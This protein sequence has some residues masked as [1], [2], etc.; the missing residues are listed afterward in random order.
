[1]TGS[2]SDEGQPGDAPAA[3]RDLEPGRAVRVPPRVEPRRFRRPVR[4]A[5][6]AGSMLL[7]VAA[8]PL[9]AFTGL[10]AARDSR[11]GEFVTLDVGP[12]EPGYQA[13]VTPT[14]VMFVEEVGSDGTP[15][16]YAVISVTNGT[17]G[18]G[19]V[20]L[21]PA[22]L[23]VEV[24][25]L[26]AT[27]LADL[28]ASS[29]L[30]AVVDAVEDL[31]DLRIPDV[32]SVGPAE[33]ATLVGPAEPITV[34]NTDELVVVDADGVS[35]T[36]FPAEEI[37][38]AADEVAVYL[39]LGV[40]GETE[41]AGLVRE[42]LFWRAWVARVADLGGDAVAGLEGDGAPTTTA[43]APAGAGTGT[44]EPSLSLAEAVVM[45]AR[46]VTQVSVIPVDGVQPLDSV[47]ASDEEY[48]AQSDELAALVADV[49]PFPVG[50][51][52]DDRLRVR[53]LDG[54]GS[55]ERALAASLDLVPAG[56]EITVFGNADSFDV[57]ESEVIYHR[58]G[59][60]DRAAAL[61]DAIDADRLVFVESSDTLVDVTVIIGADYETPPSA[62][63]APPT[64]IETAA[65]E[66]SGTD[67]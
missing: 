27:T 62:D 45:L 1:M 48:E 17:N 56:A 29:G 16:G 37:D 28:R 63:L 42:R 22:G 43:A 50:A 61:A 21:L 15:I 30:A 8:I 64:T 24:D 34:E 55:S 26:G 18:G 39:E 3:R 66:G 2:T 33:W 12:G 6:F 9:L 49:V 53:L 11:G 38:L 57:A 59:I 20:M 36:V 32:E 19:A 10:R 54:S 51:T 35:E 5:A 13:L 40:E 7:L 52:A 14:P 41:L 44:A 46:G 58:E 67:G 65:S 31:L 23:R 4:R 60:E 25:G 47:D